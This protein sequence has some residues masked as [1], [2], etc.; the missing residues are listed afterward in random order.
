MRQALDPRRLAC[1][2][3]QRGRQFAGMAGLLCLLGMPGTGQAPNPPRNVPEFLN[4]LPD[5]N[6]VARMRQEQTREL[7]F[8]AA[9]ALR[10]K[11]VAE[12]SAKL[13]KLAT[14]LKSELDKAG[15]DTL[16]VSALRKADAI[17]KLARNIKQKMTV[18]AI[19]K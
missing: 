9:N 13:L 6:D 2:H 14:D 12:D 7:D 17:E 10:Q 15:R 18:T 16:S 19:G 4:R 1:V 3:G 8:A 11:Q 5:Q